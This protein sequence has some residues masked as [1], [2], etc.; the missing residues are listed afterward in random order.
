MAKRIKTLREYTALGSFSA[1]LILRNLPFVL[2]LG[3]LGTVYIA[4]AHYSEKTVRNIQKLQGEI[5]E[6]R[7]KYLSL[8]AEIMYNSK[9]A[10]VEKRVGSLGLGRKGSRPRKILPGDS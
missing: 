7:W 9:E 6:L 3:F 4:N 1:N 5:R 10:E 2:F 8:Q